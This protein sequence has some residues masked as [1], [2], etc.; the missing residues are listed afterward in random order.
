MRRRAGEETPPVR[1]SFRGSAGQ[2]FGAFAVRG[3]TLLLEGEANDY[4]GKGLN[5]GT[6]VLSPDRDAAYTDPQAIAGNTLLYGATGGDAFFAGTVGERFA[7]RNSGATTVVEGIGDHGCE[8]MTGGR[9]VVLG[10]VGF[11]FGAGMSNGQAWVL[12][13]DD[14]LAGLINA[15]S[16]HLEAMKADDREVVRGLVEQH[17]ALTGSAYARDLLA[18]WDSVAPRFRS[19]VPKAL[20]ELRASQEE[21]LQEGAA[22]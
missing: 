19:V 9:A 3:M 7:V 18:R 16:V 15:E 10:P 12:D 4:V 6:L 8:Y 13:T 20:L 11:N 17:V 14:T 21:E 1:L 22:D 5:G 2:S